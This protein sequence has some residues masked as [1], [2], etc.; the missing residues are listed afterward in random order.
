LALLSEEHLR[1]LI[2]A[3]PVM[4]VAFDPFGR[5]L[6]WN[7]EAERVTGYSLQD[8]LQASGSG[9]A[10]EALYPDPMDR[11]RLLAEWSAK[12]NDFRD[13]RLVVTRKDGQH[14]LIS[15]SC[16]SDRRPVTG[17]G[18]W[19]VGTEVQGAEAC[20]GFAI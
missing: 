2:Q 1:E 15:W 19:L 13:W 9:F 14:R 18:C 4:L 6:C 5:I 3:M 8:L 20:L 7:A 11:A 17:W 16:E 12:G 10:L